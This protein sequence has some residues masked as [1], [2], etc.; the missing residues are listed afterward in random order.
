MSKQQMKQRS[1]LKTEALKRLLNEHA[2]HAFPHTP[3]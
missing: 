2:P 1:L 3:Q